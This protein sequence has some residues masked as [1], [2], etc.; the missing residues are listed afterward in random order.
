MRFRL[1]LAGLLL[2]LPAAAQPAQ[3]VPTVSAPVEELLASAPHLE[4]GNGL[5]T[6]RIAAKGMIPFYRPIN[7]A[8]PLMRR[9]F[10]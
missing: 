2:A 9:I 3:P 4:I 8:A 1:A 6:A 7:L 10:S 5:V